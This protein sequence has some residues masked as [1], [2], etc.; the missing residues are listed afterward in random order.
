MEPIIAQIIRTKTSVEN[1]VIYLRVR[2]IEKQKKRLTF[3]GSFS[4]LF[5]SDFIRTEKKDNYYLR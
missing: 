1:K 3:S 5:V 2:S 4:G